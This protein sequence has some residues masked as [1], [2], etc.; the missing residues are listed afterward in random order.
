MLDIHMLQMPDTTCEVQM[1]KCWTPT[2]VFLVLNL[3]A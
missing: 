3:G 2:C 1:C